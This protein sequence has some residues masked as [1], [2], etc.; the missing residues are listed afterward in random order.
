M[1]VTKQTYRF[2]SKMHCMGLSFCKCWYLVTLT[3]KFLQILVPGDF[4]LQNPF[5][6]FELLLNNLSLAHFQTISFVIEGLDV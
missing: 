2:L 1:G 5:T 6:I 3:H 4:G